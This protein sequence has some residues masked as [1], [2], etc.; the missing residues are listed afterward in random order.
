MLVL[1]SHPSLGEKRNYFTRGDIARTT[2]DT[3]V[4]ARLGLSLQFTSGPMPAFNGLFEHYFVLPAEDA[5][6]RGLEILGPPRPC[7]HQHGRLLDFLKT[8]VDEHMKPPT[9]FTIAISVHCRLMT[10]PADPPTGLQPRLSGDL[11]DHFCRPPTTLLDRD[12]EEPVLRV[13]CHRQAI[14]HDRPNGSERKL[15]GGAKGLQ[16]Q[17]PSLAPRS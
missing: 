4:V 17:V 12:H 2:Q 7:D 15:L 8:E 11:V 3:T 5:I 10:V 9:V 14:E 1:H 6:E 16:T 13:R